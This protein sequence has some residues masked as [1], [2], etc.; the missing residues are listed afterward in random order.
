[1]NPMTEDGSITPDSAMRFF[2][3]SAMREMSMLKDFHR[4][5]SV[6]GILDPTSELAPVS[7][8]EMAA[9]YED[10]VGNWRASFDAM[11]TIDAAKKQVQREQAIWAQ[12]WQEELRRAQE[13]VNLEN[14]DELLSD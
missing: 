10:D 7:V 4:T 12:R 6:Y 8:R 5:A 13:V 3:F 1:M 14:E 9:K 2:I 11:L